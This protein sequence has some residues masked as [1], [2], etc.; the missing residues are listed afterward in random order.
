MPASTALLWLGVLALSAYECCAWSISRLNG[1]LVRPVQLF[2]D[3]SAAG[4]RSTSKE[5]L[6]ADDS[7]QK[8]SPLTDTAPLAS[9]VPPPAVPIRVRDLEHL[10]FLMQLGYRVQ[11]VD[12]R[13]DCRS[14]LAA[15][16]LHPVVRNMYARKRDNAQGWNR[17]DGRKIAL[18]IEGGGMRGCVAA[19]MVTAIW[20]LGLQ[21]SIDTVYGSSAGSLVG[22][23]FITGQLP[24]FG[25][26]V[27][28]DVL[29]TAEQGAHLSYLSG[30]SQA[31][32]DM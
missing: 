17:T 15:T 20:H 5:E 32:R 24:Y 1:R 27:Y 25:T 7:L 8:P 31:K 9:T 21:D 22:A 19:G 30:S 6:R 10:R 3:D 14:D 12:V 4:E 16:S 29:T 11:D 18:A 13:G 28:Y 23:Y 2:Q 26:E